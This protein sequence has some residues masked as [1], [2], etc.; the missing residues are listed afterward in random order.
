MPRAVSR[1]CPLSASLPRALLLGFDTGEGLPPRTHAAAL[2]ESQRDREQ[3]VGG[4]Q[5]SAELA[6]KQAILLCNSHKRRPWLGSWLLFPRQSRAHLGT[7]DTGEE[8]GRGGAAQPVCCKLL[9]L[10]CKS[11]PLP[12]REPEQDPEASQPP[13]TQIPALGSSRGSLLQY[14]STSRASS[15][16]VRSGHPWRGG[17]HA[18]LGY[19]QGTHSTDRATCPRSR[20]EVVAEQRTQPAGLERTRIVG[21]LFLSGPQRGG[22]CLGH[23]NESQG[24]WR[25]CGSPSDLRGENVGGRSYC[26]RINCQPVNPLV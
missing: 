12:L 16:C 25:L 20:G 11:L 19:A 8:R 3:P 23:A 24:A 7:Y 1:S 10:C 14:P 4:R 5:P 17:Q 26:R 15:L 21:V 9:C 2:P 22:T 6:L 13:G 18:H